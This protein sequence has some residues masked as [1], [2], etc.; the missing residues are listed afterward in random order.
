MITTYY[1]YTFGDM[2][3]GS[4]FTLSWFGLNELRKPDEFLQS[5]FKFRAFE[6]NLKSV[7]FTPINITTTF[8]S[9]F[10]F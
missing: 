9:P 8:Q 3:F 1:Y 7:D 10:L 6:P 4:L 5:L 2:I